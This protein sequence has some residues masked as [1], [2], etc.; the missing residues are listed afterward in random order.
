M[1]RVGVF[2]WRGGGEGGDVCVGEVVV[3]V[4]VFVWR[5]GGDDG[6]V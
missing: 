6:D 3:R 2:V 4:G 1:V 5:G